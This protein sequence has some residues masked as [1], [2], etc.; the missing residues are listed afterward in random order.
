LRKATSS[1]SAQPADHA[2]VLHCRSDM[3]SAVLAR[4]AHLLKVLPH[5]GRSIDIFSIPKYVANLLKCR[6]DTM[7]DCI[8]DVEHDG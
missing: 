6:I 2:H 7:Y 5:A 1:L 4:F 3:A 8:G